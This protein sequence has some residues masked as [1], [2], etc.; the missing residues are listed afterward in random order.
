[1]VERRGQCAVGHAYAWRCNVFW[2]VCT[3]PKNAKMDVVAAIVMLLDNTTG[4]WDKA[5]DLCRPRGSRCHTTKWSA[6]QQDQKNMVC[7]D[8]YVQIKRMLDARRH[9]MEE[10]SLCLDIFPAYTNI[11]KSSSSF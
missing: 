11:Q 10:T 9:G 7:L 8:S 2:K 6:R 1:M 5:E 3:A 4:R